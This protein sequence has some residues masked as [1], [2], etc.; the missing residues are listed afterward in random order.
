MSA[1]KRDGAAHCIK[2]RPWASDSWIQISPVLPFGPVIL[3]KF[4]NS[5]LYFTELIAFWEK[6][7]VDT[8]GIP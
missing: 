2:L 8:Y 4:L 6:C 5:G 7:G 1:S 3:R